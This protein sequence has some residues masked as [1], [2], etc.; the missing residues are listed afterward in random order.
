MDLR[1]DEVLTGVRDL[2]TVELH[3]RSRYCWA[4]LLPGVI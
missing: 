2:L 3:E 1:R 4:G